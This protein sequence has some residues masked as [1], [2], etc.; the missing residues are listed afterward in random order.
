MSDKQSIEKV[1]Q[2]LDEQIA[3]FPTGR[4]IASAKKQVPIKMVNTNLEFVTGSTGANT[5]MII[6]GICEVDGIKYAA[7]YDP[8]ERPPKQYV[9]EIYLS[10]GGVGVKGFRLIQDPTEWGVIVDFFEKQHVWEHKRI[11]RWVM[12]I[13]NQQLHDVH[14]QVSKFQQWL[15]MVNKSNP[16]KNSKPLTV[17]DFLRNSL[18][19][20]RAL[21]RK[22]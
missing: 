8:R 14:N 7:L 19:K 12:N 2:L 16:N 1:D 11:L 3:K 10:P 4:D 17:Q 18:Q 15:S 22:R 5:G 13:R 21:G 9:E 6:C 20:V